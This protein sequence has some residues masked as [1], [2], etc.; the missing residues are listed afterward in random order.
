MERE[1]GKEKVREQGQRGREEREISKRR[2]DRNKD[3]EMR[4][5]NTE[6]ESWQLRG[7][8]RHTKM[9]RRNARER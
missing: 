7:T 3:T 1:G 5:G 9:K 4:G 6:R 2:D 8:E